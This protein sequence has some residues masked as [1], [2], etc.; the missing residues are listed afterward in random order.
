MADPD[1]WSIRKYTSLDEVYIE[2]GSDR[3]AEA[4][5]ISLSLASFNE[6]IDDCIKIRDGKDDLRNGQA[7]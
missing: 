2:V 7:D 5:I 1:W 6:F 3:R 4:A